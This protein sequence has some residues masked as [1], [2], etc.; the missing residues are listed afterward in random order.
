MDLLKARMLLGLSEM[1]G[2]EEIKRAY[3]MKVRRHHPDTGKSMPDVDLFTEIHEAYRLLTSEF[4]TEFLNQDSIENPFT[5][6][7]RPSEAAFSD[8][9]YTFLDIT[10][11]DAFK[12]SVIT[13]NTGDRETVCP[14]CGGMGLVGRTASRTCSQCSGT[15]TRQVKWGNEILDVVCV[16]CSGTGSVNP[17]TCTLCKGRGRITHNRNVRISLPRGARSG[18]VLKLPGQG[19]WNSEKKC[20]GNL[21]VEINVTMPHDWELK[22]LDIYAPVKTDIW[23]VLSGD[24]VPVKTM[25]GTIMHRLDSSELSTGS[26][27]IEGRG[28]IN[29]DGIR[30]NHVGLLRIMF[31]DFPPSE[32]ARLLINHL[33]HTWPAGNSMPIRILPHI[34]GQ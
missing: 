33:R 23:S 17:F 7:S 14:R 15:G 25:D 13:I 6:D 2:L 29:E 4:Q 1:D 22:G 26:I 20:R 27:T 5:Q 32:T 34:T 31:P 3:R 12:G 30:G 10:S 18:M 19:P 21:Y 9:L 28:W 16:K 11:E 24:P 8:S